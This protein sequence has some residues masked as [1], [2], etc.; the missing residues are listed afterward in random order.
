[1]KWLFSGSEGRARAPCVRPRPRE[2]KFPFLQGFFYISSSP[3]H[4]RKTEGVVLISCWA[5]QWRAFKKGQKLNSFVKR[6][7]KN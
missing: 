7:S 3:I 4:G 1:M 2:G 6:F 5:E